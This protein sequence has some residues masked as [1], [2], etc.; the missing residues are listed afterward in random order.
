MRVTVAKT[1]GFCFGVERAVRMVNSLLDKG[2]KVCALGPIIHNE[3]VTGALKARGVVE[4]ENADDVPAGYTLVIRSH[5][6]SKSD[7]DLIK[8]SKVPFEDATCP[9]VK[10]IHTIVEKESKSGKTILIAGDE[11]HPE[12]KGIRGYCLGESFTV[13]DG[14]KLEELVREGKIDEKTEIILVAQ[15]TFR[16]SEWGKCKSLTKNLFTNSSIYD[17]ICNTTQLRQEEAKYLSKKSDCMVV[18][19]GRNSSNTNKLFDICRNYCDAFFVETKD[20]LPI[21]RLKNYKCAGI[22]AGASTPGDIIR[23]VRDV[24]AGITKEDGNNQE[25]FEQLLEESLKGLGTGGRVKGTV[26]NITPTEVYVDVGRKQAGVVPLS[27]LTRDPNA[28]PEDIVKIGDELDLLITKVDDQ[29][30]MITLSK[31]RV[32]AD[33]EWN[34]IVK[35]FG[36][37]E[38]LT[39]IVKKVVKGGIIASY[40]FVNVFIPSSH[41][42]GS[43]N[44][45]FESYL[46]KEVR[47]RIIEIDKS[48]K[49]VVGSIRDVIDEERDAKLEKFW[50]DIEV[51]KKYVGTVRSMT[52][53]GVFVDL[54]PIDGM[55]HISELSWNHVA[56]PS[57]VVEVGQEIEV[58]VKSFDKE[59]GKI[60]LV[61]KKEEDNPW[62]RIKREYPVGKS[63]EAE[64]VGILPYGAFARI[65]PGVDGLIHVS[66]ISDHRIETPNEVLSIGDVVKV[67]VRE[68]DEERKRVSLTMKD[69]D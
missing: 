6:I 42:G 20:R 13:K 47:F 23:E 35:S 21:E 4:V 11:N 41:V 1:A 67:K 24:M 10:K 12:V 8:K 43:K 3:Q 28:K 17:T 31:V 19:G 5:G 38:V 25:N 65:E 22:T 18:I 54:G 69:V 30:G 45:P 32:D 59:K 48:R 14:E 63:F 36:D 53:Y 55:V 29:E 2:I 50:N 27:E 15:T 34:A 64:I 56:K 37:K 9:F 33:N 58:R 44:I 51:G 66:Q 52:N 46:N 62:E 60:A 26:A 68:I 61:Y 39:G 7:L 16:K 57:E 40:K 49:R